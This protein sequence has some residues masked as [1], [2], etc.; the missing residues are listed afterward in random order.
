MAWKAGHGQ[1]TAELEVIRETV[2]CRMRTIETGIE[3]NRMP[4]SMKEGEVT[5]RTRAIDRRGRD[6]GRQEQNTEA[7]QE[8]PA[9]VELIEKKKAD[10][11]EGR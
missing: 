4:V 1:T 5:D 9:I 2:K 11:R 8:T 3:K 7:H 10:R 6:R